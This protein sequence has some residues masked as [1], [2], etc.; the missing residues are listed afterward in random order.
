MIEVKRLKN[1]ILVKGHAGYA[2]KGQD[3][4][5]CAVSVLT[6]TLIESAESLTA[7]NITYDIKSGI[8]IIKFRHPSPSLG[9]LIDAFFVGINGV[10]R[11]YPAYVKIG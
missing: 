8:A 1:G 11:A 7:D 9:I 4:V 3:I 10:A 5:C 6:Q 2:E